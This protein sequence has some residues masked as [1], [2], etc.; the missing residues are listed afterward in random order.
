M[1]RI[2]TLETFRTPGIVVAAWCMLA[3]VS[4]LI[5]VKIVV[6]QIPF[7]VALNSFCLFL[8]VYWMERLS[9]S[10]TQKKVQLN[11][12]H[13]ENTEVQLEAGLG[14]KETTCK[15]ASEQEPHTAK[16]LSYKLIFAHLIHQYTNF[17]IGFWIGNAYIIQVIRSIEPSITYLLFSSNYVQIDSVVHSITTL[18]IALMHLWTSPSSIGGSISVVMNSILLSYRNKLLRRLYLLPSY[19][20]QQTQIFKK[21]ALSTAIIM[22]IFYILLFEKALQIEWHWKW[23]L[24]ACLGHSTYLAFNIMLL[25]SWNTVLYSAAS[26]L[27]RT[28]VTAFL[29]ILT[30]FITH[31]L[32]FQ[33]KEQI[34]TVLIALLGIS[35]GVY[36]CL[37]HTF[38]SKRMIF[39][40]ICVSFMAFVTYLFLLSQIAIRQKPNTPNVSSSDLPFVRL[41][42][43]KVAIYTAAGN[44]N[45]GDNMQIHSWLAHFKSWNRRNY[46]GKRPLEIF[47]L[48]GEFCCYPFDDRRKYVVSTVESLH[49]FL[50]AQQPDYV[51]IGGGGIFS[52]PHFPWAINRSWKDTLELF[53]D[54]SWVFAAVGASEGQHSIEIA[55]NTVGLLNH[56]LVVAARDTPSQSVLSATTSTNVTLL[57]DPVL[58]DSM[59]FPFQT[60]KNKTHHDRITCWILRQPIPESLAKILD[61]YINMEKDLFFALEQQDGNFF[62][63]FKS[64]VS[65]YSTEIEWFWSNIQNCDF[66]VSM[67]YHGAI[68]G[69][70]AGIPTLA[71]EFEDRGRSSHKIRY[72]FEDLL[73]HS[74]CVVKHIDATEFDEKFKKC[75]LQ[76][77]NALKSRLDEL[78]REFTLFM[79]TTFK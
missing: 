1:F 24:F 27:K 78:D 14:C 19:A 64:Q 54:V 52:H 68:L 28:F 39:A 46:G 7:M 33:F 77:G 18:L 62:R 6:L 73:G 61:K 25:K 36:V 34:S 17:A 15:F 9:S 32:N 66:V 43:M 30:W 53:P 63:R 21:I 67:R 13:D 4:S 35:S 69:F 47:S 20:Q 42:P 8:F 10:N 5:S 48:S 26:V 65:V 37:N 41:K 49:N 71:I 44:G 76:K 60:S 56:S 75:Q 38:S 40:T 74:D 50:Y 3:V 72:L 45:L 58:L 57:R 12:H 23:I 29:F 70:R 16:L 51:M 31:T 11:N 55:S 59:N 22:V 79:D 2:P